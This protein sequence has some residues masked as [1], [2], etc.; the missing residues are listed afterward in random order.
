[1]R[2]SAPNRTTDG[3]PDMNRARPSRPANGGE[4]YEG[5]R[6]QHIR[7]LFQSHNRGRKPLSP[8]DVEVFPN[9]QRRRHEPR[10]NLPDGFAEDRGRDGKLAGKESVGVP[11]LDPVGR[12]RGIRK[13]PE[14]AG[15]DRVAASDYGCRQNV[16]IIGIGQVERGNQRLV[17]GD[18]GIPRGPVH[19]IARSFQRRA[20][21]AGFVSEQG[22]D[23]LVVNRG[24]PS[25][26]ENVVDRQ[27]Q[28]N[29]P[30]RRGIEDVGV[31][32]SRE[33]GQRTR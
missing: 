12:D 9:G 15:N 4:G 21:A 7:I 1:M 28:K 27:L 5:R 11:H 18:Y 2:I 19:E 22:V 31:E 6:S 32:K 30:H 20:V 23:P 29:I 17:S 14:V 13:V 24:G 10:A 33:A 16:T 8:K 26:P 3:V 25:R